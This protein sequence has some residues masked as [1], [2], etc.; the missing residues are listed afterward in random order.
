M[1]RL[2][3]VTVA[4]VAASVVQLGVAWG[5]APPGPYSNG[6]ET[7]TAGW[8]T[9]EGAT[10]T[11]RPSGYI[12]PSGYASGVPSATGNYHARLGL[13]PNP[14]T[15]QSGGG[16]QPVFYGPYTDW[17]GD[18]SA[19]FPPGGYQTGVDIYLD[20]PYALTHPD[21]RFD[22][23]SAINDTTG[24]FRRDFV[25]NVGTDPLGFVM[26]GGNN[27][28][29]CGANPSDPGHTPVHI[30]QSGWYTFEHTFSGVQGGPLVVT[31][32]VTQKST[33][34]VMGTWVRSDPS[35]IIGVTVGG[36][37]YGWFVQNEFP[38]LAI[39]NSF[40]TGAMSTPGCTVTITNGGWITANNGD[41]G[42]FG[43]NAKVSSGGSPSGQ[44]QYQDHGPVQ[45]LMAK[46]LSIAA[47]VCSDD[48]TQATII[49]SASVNGS[50]SYEY[51]IDV[52]DGGEPGTNDT[53]GIR[54]PG[55][56][57]DSGEQNLGGGNIQIR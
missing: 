26:S 33:S 35:D 54:I 11:R 28:T 39:D 10:V 9:L 40:R 7:N 29:R 12:S 17:G 24:N 30:T 42:S 51:E 37:A 5:D 21:T 52:T 15:C 19:I 22:W 53:Y 20:V 31:L 8:Y 46:S 3:V 27:A 38:D 23:D 57:Y 16:P 49:G 45:P 55:V 48:R 50:G 43:G 4:L 2:A 36:N 34:I 56:A 1:N 14:D 18:N 44:E 47:I 25:F 32:T 13:D 41:R 6:F